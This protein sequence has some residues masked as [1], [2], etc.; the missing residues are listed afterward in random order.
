MTDAADFSPGATASSGL[1]VTYTSSAP[2]VA[3]IVGGQIHIVGAGTTTITA[4]QSGNV[5][6]APATNVARTLTVKAAT[7]TSTWIN[8]AGGA[9]E[10]PA[11]WLSDSIASGNASIADFSTLDL[12]GDTTVTL[13]ITPYTVAGLVFGDSTPDSNWILSGSQS[14]TLAITSGTPE[15]VVAN[16]SATI[17]TALKGSSGLVK[18]GPGTFNLSA[19]NSYTGSTTID[20]G[21][22]DLGTNGKLYNSGYNNID[23]VTVRAGATLRMADLGYDKPS[24]LG[25]LSNYRQ[26]RVLD[27]GTMEI[28]GASQ[29]TGQ[30]F[31]VTSAGGSLRYTPGGQTLTHTG[32]TNS[33]IQL[34]G[35]LTFDAIGNITMSELMA[36]VGGILKTGGGTL[37][38]NNE[39]NPFSGN[40]SIGEGPV[41]TG[42]NQA[43]GTNGYLGA[44]NGSRSITIQPGASLVLQGN[45]NFG[46]AGKTAAG[47]PTVTINGG[48]LNALRF[49]ILGNLFLNGAM[50]TQSSADSGVYQGWQ[51]IGPVTVGG[52]TV[53]TIDSGNG[54]ANHLLG[55][56]TTVFSVANATNSDAADLIVTTALRDGSD[57]YPGVGS[58]QKSGLG[59]M[60][61]AGG[62]SY[63][64]STSVTEGTLEI[65]GSTAAGA[66]TIAPAATL[67]GTGIL[68]GPVTVAGNL[69]PGINGVGTL[70]INNSLTLAGSTNMELHK[71]D[72]TLTSDLLDGMTALTLGGNL[73]VT[74]TGDALAAGDTFVLFTMT[75][76]SATGS[77]A[78]INLPTLPGSMVWDTTLLIGSGTIKVA[79]TLSPLE[80]WREQNFNISTNTG[81]AAN[82]ADPDHDGLTNLVEYALDLDP[83]SAGTT[84]TALITDITTGYL[85]STVVKN[86]LATDL[87]YEVQVSSDLADW[88]SVE[89]TDIVTE[90]NTTNSLIVRDSTPIT[91]APHRSIRL[92]VTSTAQVTVP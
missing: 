26:R 3:T 76:G 86:P 38:L 80:N 44:V 42:T 40:V 15:I 1:V 56:S 65:T 27:G 41:Q 31:T 18:T 79:S 90:E 17:A 63:T 77:F 75:S 88:N 58:L 29:S 61:L 22:L 39:A 46:G 2:T 16:Q 43:G 70:T 11:N 48:T 51:F 52:S 53:T 66:T 64:G 47:I 50:L 83:N 7:T 62:N 85:R 84:A 59:T 54:K 91:A 10:T 6:F 82:D 89:G 9:W 14:L 60:R 23:I 73:S 36:G 87:T 57:D 92:K 8:P 13:N 71:S 32:N 28:T 69:E 78:T 25:Q 21:V 45:N 55:T 49:N 74:A 20:S 5:S 12:A 33:D 34:D 72:A 81:D 4:S 67:A 19:I 68:T 37:L 35:P 30:N 24:S